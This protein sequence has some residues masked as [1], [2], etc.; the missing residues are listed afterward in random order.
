MPVAKSGGYDFTLTNG[1]EIS[2]KGIEIAARFNWAETGDFSWDA[3]INYGRNRAVV[4]SLPDVIKV[5]S[6]LLSPIFSLEM[7][8]DLEL[9]A[10]E[11][12]FLVN[13]TV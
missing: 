13:Y 7:K 9:V 5:G 2:S 10:E 8:G 3:Q 1:G 12:N 4:E 6:I 11:E